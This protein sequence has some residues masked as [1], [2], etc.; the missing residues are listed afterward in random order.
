MHPGGPWLAFHFVKPYRKLALFSLVMLLP[1]VFLDL[2]VPRLRELIID[3]GIKKSNGTMV[4]IVSVIMLVFSV[5]STAA[6]LKSNSAVMVGESVVR[7]LREEVFVKIQNLS[8][9]NLDRF[10]SGSLMIRLTSTVQRL[11][12][13]SL[14]VGT[15]RRFR[16]PGAPCLCSSLLPGSRW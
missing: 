4:L 8:H 14:W 7:D 11:V 3:Q 12:Q 16:R 15:G 10:S 5:L 13:V 9:G 2:A 1:M 6:V